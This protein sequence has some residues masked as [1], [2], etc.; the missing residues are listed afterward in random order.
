MHFSAQKVR[1][2]YDASRK[3]DALCCSSVYPTMIHVDRS[4]LQKIGGNSWLLAISE[5]MAIGPN[6]LGFI[7]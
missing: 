5:P 2:A 1:Y 4:K 6:T 7:G 3:H